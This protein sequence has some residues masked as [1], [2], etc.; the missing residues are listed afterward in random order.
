[1]P[2][3]HANSVC[4]LYT[5]TMAQSWAEPGDDNFFAC[6][7][8]G[9]KR[10][11]S[12]PVHED[13][14]PRPPNE[15]AHAGD[16]L[17]SIIMNDMLDAENAA[18]DPTNTL[19]PS[20]KIF[21]DGDPMFV[22]SPVHEDPL[23]PPPNEDAHSGDR[24]ARLFENNMT[25]FSINKEEML[26]EDRPN[27]MLDAGSTI[28]PSR[29]ITMTVAPQV[30]L[31]VLRTHQVQPYAF[32]LTRALSQDEWDT[33]DG[34]DG[35]L[36][37]A[38]AAFGKQSSTVNKNEKKKT[39]TKSTVRDSATR[40]WDDVRSAGVSQQQLVWVQ[41]QQQQMWAQQQHRI[42]LWAQH[43]AQTRSGASLD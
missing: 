14:P 34:D 13:P 37:M 33:G 36:A 7:G 25:R 39:I 32:L 23:P 40:V 19:A 30:C 2:C 17:A 18:Q 28:A 42:A 1:M 6:W 20:S 9:E 35:A 11:A 27:D 3:D 38:V 21:G 15:D 43:E 31:F 26:V 4:I 41:Q 22:S 16:C 12:W 10:Q 8:D 24:L 5:P 29:T